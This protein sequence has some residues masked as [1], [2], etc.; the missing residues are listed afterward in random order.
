MYRWV[1]PAWEEG[2][3]CFL[4][5]QNH[6]IIGMVSCARKPGCEKNLIVGIYMTYNAQVLTRDEFFAH[7]SS[8]HGFPP[9]LTAGI[10][11]RID[12]FTKL[13]TTALSVPHDAYIFTAKGFEGAVRAMQK[14]LDTIAEHPEIFRGHRPPLR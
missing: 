7:M 1:R 9:T 6:E 10:V 11:P 12:R 3:P 13:E 2:F 14:V 4:L 8:T 5:L